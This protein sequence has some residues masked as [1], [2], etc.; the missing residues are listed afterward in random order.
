MQRSLKIYPHLVGVKVSAVSVSVDIHPSESLAERGGE[1]LYLRYE[2]QFP[3]H[4]R[5]QRRAFLGRKDMLVWSSRRLVGALLGHS[6]LRPVQLRL[7]CGQAGREGKAI[8]F[9]ILQCRVSNSG[10]GGGEGELCK[11]RKAPMKA[12][13]FET[14]WRAAGTL[15]HC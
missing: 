1:F 14:E 8:L 4:K 10:D 13:L 7:L 15:P 5:I 9:L 3:R 6:I 11:S 12:G 2:A